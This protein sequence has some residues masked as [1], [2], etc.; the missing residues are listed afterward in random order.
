MKRNRFGQ[1]CLDRLVRLA[2]LE[3]V[4]SLVLSGKKS[5]EIKATLRTDLKEAFRSERTDVRGSID[6]TITI[7]TKV[8]LTV[9][10]EL[11]SI[12]IDGLELLKR[13]P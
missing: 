7:L 3:K 8:W 1:I 9:P 4:S 5:N 12:M 6:K 13:V 2:W 11:E 10:E